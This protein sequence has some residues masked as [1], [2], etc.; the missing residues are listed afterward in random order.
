MKKFRT[1]KKHLKKQPRLKL[2]FT[3][4]I[5]WVC[6]TTKHLS[7]SPHQI[8]QLIRPTVGEPRRFPLSVRRRSSVSVKLIRANYSH[9]TTSLYVCVYYFKIIYNILCVT[10]SMTRCVRVGWLRGWWVGLSVCHNFRK[11]K[12]HLHASIGALVNYSMLLLSN[13]FDLIIS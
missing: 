3:V 6:P 9:R 5:G 10:F 13:I 7:Q 12:L 4:W 8:S 11:G 1:K 2:W